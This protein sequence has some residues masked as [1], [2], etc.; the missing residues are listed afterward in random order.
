MPQVSLKYLLQGSLWSTARSCITDMYRLQWLRVLGKS[1]V[2]NYQPMLD[3]S[4]VHFGLSETVPS[5]ARMTQTISTW[6]WWFS[7]TF[8]VWL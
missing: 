6:W 7:T 3:G 4:F 8:R 2:L 1:R 5:Y